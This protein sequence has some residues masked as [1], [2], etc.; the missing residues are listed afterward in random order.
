MS[1]LRKKLKQ[2]NSAPTAFKCLPEYFL[3]LY[4]QTALYLE[5]ALE[6]EMTRGQVLRGPIVTSREDFD[7]CKNEMTG[8]LFAIGAGDGAGNGE[9][10]DIAKPAESEVIIEVS[11]K[12]AQTIITEKLG[13]QVDQGSQQS[14]K[15]TM[16]D[17]LIIQPVAAAFLQQVQMIGGATDN[18]TIADRS[19]SVDGFKFVKFAKQEQWLQLDFPIKMKQAPKDDKKATKKKKPNPNINDGNHDD[20]KLTLYMTHKIAQNIIRLGQ[21]QQNRKVIDKDSPWAQHMRSTMLAASRSLEIVLEDLRLSIADCTRLELGQVIA[22]PGASHERLSL[23]TSG[24]RGK[25]VLTTA[26]L[27]VFKS[28]KAIKLNADID[29]EFLGELP[30]CT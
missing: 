7:A 13:G 17:V 18:D 6:R 3:G 9:S 14:K 24:G 26:T 27:G 28:N 29:P 5:N 4:E 15:F 30:F 8:L 10:E 21:A 11:A 19:S 1:V 2:E 23:K 16:F 25:I 22:L 12:L 20:L